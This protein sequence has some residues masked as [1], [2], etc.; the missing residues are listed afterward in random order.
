MKINRHTW[1]LYEKALNTEIN[2]S[3][4]NLHF[5]WRL[6]CRLVIHRFLNVW[7]YSV[8][9]TRWHEW[10]ELSAFPSPNGSTFLKLQENCSL[11]GQC[12]PGL[13]TVPAVRNHVFFSISVAESYS[14]MCWWWTAGILLKQALCKYC[15]K[16]LTTDCKYC[17]DKV[18]RICLLYTAGW[19]YCLVKQ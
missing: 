4:G 8:C 2:G 10:R 13:F 5:P 6:L 16:F 19:P 15:W 7:M 18:H 11:G 3:F 1:W 12:G 9:T 17:G 14:H